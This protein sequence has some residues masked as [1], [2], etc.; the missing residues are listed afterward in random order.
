VDS[1]SLYLDFPE[2]KSH[3]TGYSRTAHFV[4]EVMSQTNP[5]E[6]VRRGPSHP[7]SC[8][9][10]PSTISLSPI[11]DSHLTIPQSLHSLYPKS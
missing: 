5:K 2:A 8:I 7:N 9:P 6:S 4:L 1:L 3:G 11:T 10:F